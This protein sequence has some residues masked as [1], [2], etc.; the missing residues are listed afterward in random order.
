MRLMQ[1]IYTQKKWIKLDTSGNKQGIQA[2]FDGKVEQL[3]FVPKVEEDE[4]TYPTIY[5]KPNSQ[6]ILLWL[7]LRIHL[8]TSNFC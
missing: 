8:T 5:V 2:D 1:S 6:T 7:R 4:Y 3:A